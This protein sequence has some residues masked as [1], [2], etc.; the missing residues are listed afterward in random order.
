MNKFRALYFFFSQLVLLFKSHATLFLYLFFR[1]LKLNMNFYC[2]FLYLCVSV[3]VCVFDECVC[4]YVVWMTEFASTLITWKKKTCNLSRRR[5]K[6]EADSWRQSDQ[7]RL[8]TDTSNKQNIWSTFHLL[9]SFWQMCAELPWNWPNEVNITLWRG[10]TDI[11]ECKS[12]ANSFKSQIMNNWKNLAAY[13]A[14]S[15]K[16][17]QLILFWE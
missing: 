7:N 9:P 12:N 5:K 1:L 10:K 16:K 15:K 14:N 17:Q 2:F 11:N 8:K 13:Y 3:R 6:P 4:V